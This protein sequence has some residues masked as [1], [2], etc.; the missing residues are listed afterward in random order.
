MVPAS[1]I[2]NATTSSVPVM[3]RIEAVNMIEWQSRRECLSSCESFKKT[4]KHLTPLLSSTAI[5][6]SLDCKITAPVQLSVW[7]AQAHCRHTAYVTGR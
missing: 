1:A 2:S 5:V 3:Q 4:V 6:N 7:Y